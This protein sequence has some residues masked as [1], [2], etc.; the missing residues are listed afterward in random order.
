MKAEEESTFIFATSRHDHRFCPNLTAGIRARQ[1]PV[2]CTIN[3]QWAK[4]FL[5]TFSGHDFLINIIQKNSFIAPLTSIFF[6]GYNSISLGVMHIVDT[7]S[8]A[9]S[10]QKQ[11]KY[12]KNSIKQNISCNSA[13]PTLMTVWGYISGQN[14]LKKVW[15]AFLW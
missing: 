5:K 2:C 15:S 10:G 9:V 3:S 8:V 12:S 11:G 6:S 14:D 7:I 13:Q 1:M 4:L